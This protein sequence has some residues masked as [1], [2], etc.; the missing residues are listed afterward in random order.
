MKKIY[1]FT[2]T[3]NSYHVAK[4]I[5]ANL[6]C[7]FINIAEIIESENLI[8]SGEAL[9]LIFPVYAMGIPQMIGKFLT[10]LK[11]E[12]EPYIFAIGTCGGSGYGIPFSL[13]DSILK[14]KKEKNM[15]PLKLSYS[16]YLQVPDNYLKIFKMKS[17]EESKIMVDLADDKLKSKIQDIEGKKKNSYDKSLINPIFKIIYSLWLGNLKK[18]DKKFKVE[19]SCISCSLCRD[20]CPSK[21]IEMVDGKPKWNGKC[22][23]CMGCIH[24]CPV[25]AIQIGEKSQKSGRYLN[26]YVTTEE[27]KIKKF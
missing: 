20:I 18:A 21:N 1:Y 15:K 3:G 26:P 23:D 16:S 25:L 12:G 10:K 2:G 13:I 7:E 6:K 22:Q 17:K 8:F 9:G 5:A 19:S 27:L 24:I 4:K 11:I 14:E